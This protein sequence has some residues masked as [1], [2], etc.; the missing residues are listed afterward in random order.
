[1]LTILGPS[2]ERPSRVHWSSW[3]VSACLG[4]FAGGLTSLF[5]I[6][7]SDHSWQDTKGWTLMIVLHSFLIAAILAFWDREVNLT[8]STG[9]LN[10]MMLFAYCVLSAV[11]LILVS[12]SSVIAL[13]F[14]G[15]ALINAAVA[16]VVYTWLLRLKE[17]KITEA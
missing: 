3:P 9:V 1:M 5:S 2:Q 14:S 12:F 6:F 4:A 17:R 16:T 10:L 13:F 11:L 7:V 15:E 8:T